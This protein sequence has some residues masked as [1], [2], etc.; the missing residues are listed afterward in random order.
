MSAN[1][2]A[3]GGAIFQTALLLDRRR[4]FSVYGFHEE[5][6]LRELHPSRE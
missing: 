3:Q 2:E 5:E 4:G 1:D 6:S